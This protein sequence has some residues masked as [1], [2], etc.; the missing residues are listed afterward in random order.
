[1]LLHCRHWLLLSAM[2]GLS[3]GVAPAVAAPALL[4]PTEYGALGAYV[5]GADVLMPGSPAAVRVATHW[6]TSEEACVPLG[7]VQVQVRMTGHGRSADLFRGQTDDTGA[8]DARFQV[9][10]WPAGEYTLVVETQIGPQQDS[11]S[12][13]VQLAGGGRLLLQS[14]K[15]LYQ[16][17]QI[18]HLRV[19]ALRDQDGVPFSKGQVRLE[20]LDPRKNQVLST[21]RPLSD[22]GIV[23]VDLP[24]AD[25][26]VL[27]S[28]TVRAV[29]V[30]GPASSGATP[31]DDPRNSVAPA[32]LK[33]TVSRF[34]P[35][36]FKL[37]ME[38]DQR[39][40]APGAA[41]RLA[42]RGRYPKGQPV[43]GAS[44]DIFAGVVDGRESS[45]A[46]RFA[47]LHA[48][49][50]K[51]G[52]AK[53]TF[54]LP[55]TLQHKEGWL[56]L[57]ATAVDG[58]GHR[59]PARMRAPL[60]KLPV[61]VDFVAEAGSLIPE[62]QNRVW[63]I[64]TYPDGS[65]AAGVE[66][67]LLSEPD[68]MGADED[69]LRRRTDAMGVATFLVKPSKSTAESKSEIKRCGSSQRAMNVQVSERSGL[70]GTQARCMN[71]DPHGGLLLRTDRAIYP[72]GMP[73]E[74]SVE[75]LGGDG[76]A[77]V[78]ILKEEQIVSTT[79]VP[80]RGG[81]G[82]VTLP[83]DPRRAGT[84]TLEAYRVA[85]SGEKF[86]DTRTIY[87]ERPNALQVE[88]RPE[89]GSDGSIRPSTP[90]RIHVRVRDAVSGA[91]VS[92]A[93]GVSLVDEALLALH[94]LPE[95]RTRAFFNLATQAQEAG[96]LL[97]ARPGGHTIEELLIGRDA[98]QDL[99]ALRQQAAQILLAGTPPPS[100]GT[101]ETDPWERRRAAWG[102]QLQRLEDA[103][104]AYRRTHRVGER[105]PGTR[106]EWRWRHDLVQAMAADGAIARRD[107]RDPWGQ[108]IITERIT[109][110]AAHPDFDS[111]A[112]TELNERMTE[113]YR[114]LAAERAADRLVP[115]PASKGR[116][117]AILITPEDLAQLV[118]RQKLPM[119]RLF[120]PWGNRFRLLEKKQPFVVGGIWSRFFLISDGPDG[121]S[122]TADD[123]V[124]HNG[125]CGDPSYHQP[126]RSLVIGVPLSKI[127]APQKLEGPCEAGRGYGRG[128]GWLGGRRAG[129]PDVIPGT[130]ES[131]YWPPE[132]EPVRA[133]F[134]ET[135][136]WR[137]Q[138][139]T[140]SRGEAVLQLDL[141]DALKTWRLSAEALAQDGR[142]G[143][144]VLPVR[145]TREILVDLDLPAVWT[146]EDELSVPVTV[147]N[148]TKSPQ[149]VRIDLTTPSGFERLSETT[150]HIDLLPGQRASR[151]F[152]MRAREVG[153]H[154]LLVLA[155]TEGA[156][157]KR[158]TL[159]RTVDVRPKGMAQTRA[160][161]D[162][163][164]S[165]VPVRHHL[166]VPAA[167]L[168]GA[169]SAILKLYPAAGTHVEEGLDALLLQP[170]GGFEQSA[171]IV[172]LSALLS[173]HLRRTG[174]LSQPLAQKTEAALQVGYQRLLAFEVYGGGF[175]PFPGKAPANQILTAYA[176]EALH[177]LKEVYP[178]EPKLL[179]RTER[180]LLAK[181]RPDGSFAPDR[182]AWYEGISDRITR[183]PACMTAYIAA[184][185]RRIRPDSAPMTMSKAA[186]YVQRTMARQASPDPFALALYAE[187]L[188]G[189]V[190]QRLWALRTE[191][192]SEKDS[193]VSF[194]PT[195]ET[196]LQA[197]GQAA[198]L[199]TTAMAASV[200]LRAPENR[201]HAELALKYLRQNMDSAGTYY[202][203]PATARAQK[204]LLQAA[205]MGQQ[206]PR[207]TLLLKV[208]QQ[209]A[210][211]LALDG[212]D[213]SLRRLDLPQLALPGGHDIE[214][215]FSGSGQL[216][217]QIVSTYHQPISPL[218]SKRKT[219][220]PVVGF[221]ALSET[222][223]SPDVEV[224]Y[225]LDASQL[226]VGEILY[227]QV[228]IRTRVQLNMPIVSAGIP[229]GFDLD[230]EQLQTLVQSRVIE[231]FQRLPN[232]VLFYLRSLTSGKP[233]LL[234]L[235]LKARLPGRVLVPPPA[236][237]ETHYPEH[238]ITGLP[239]VVTVLPQP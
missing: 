116:R 2:F 105:V 80:L 178:I 179:G 146:Q 200:F 227:E 113:I 135:L 51:E 108:P 104:L 40:Y 30:K 98:R 74:L 223:R 197:E 11:H 45:Y 201:A 36:R 102:P 23:A 222:P 132:P 48:Q 72:Q 236:L 239:V 15:L 189:D 119:G 26:L 210:R 12:Q 183:D 87:V 70:V 5:R 58:A 137:P 165:G 181:Q 238:R 187:L 75:S 209:P 159:E 81:Q 170:S 160:L 150:Q 27:G 157:A 224:G 41:V 205:E 59:E 123:Q 20:V 173:A 8:A 190:H 166:E 192:R 126:V 91:G 163:L 61:W 214:L 111:F 216:D 39:Y 218:E 151:S 66:M 225:L 217:Y 136:L 134:P 54:K 43:A 69:P 164:R 76:V 175:S 180:W 6:A 19:M 95:G 22:H 230:D 229:P 155:S 195:K 184:T 77:Y 94:P 109:Q 120:D 144:V 148:V 176:L 149:R 193:A 52:E 49:L 213:L 142:M 88:L 167:A 63:G 188:G 84:L 97:R 32:E 172:H 10:L 62:F 73:L 86:R 42:L 125:T 208:D 147:Q 219:P 152:R 57:D 191:T 16:P 156:D 117:L 169:G 50:D 215:L 177:A 124:A 9:P 44:V 64:A 228:R 122:G 3:L 158:E 203:T 67:E 168:S 28:Y 33:L 90:G 106:A 37:S 198:I 78:D 83:P 85:P 46:A 112:R 212:R 145:V 89:S 199:E 110:D 204:V 34:T 29:W 100:K 226:A 71:I 211:S 182:D 174:Q 202:A 1:M 17:S 185:L 234:P 55:A 118:E 235:R 18:M 220:E 171:S 47:I 13:K 140:D 24:L 79:A 161:Q 114:G 128:A 56:Q 21:Q 194:V 153:L 196:L 133:V 65:P 233:L 206:I 154:K 101:W 127:F 7:R 60:S 231:R 141:P 31:A 82:R 96:R 92:A 35:P 232:E 143:E 131:P 4:T 139:L 25:E 53:L 129:A 107:V 14:D 237:H 103:F 207:G 38:P 221:P 115:D 68:L 162:R 130:A 99:G 138:V 93:V 186:E 121:V